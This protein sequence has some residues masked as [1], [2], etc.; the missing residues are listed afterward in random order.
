LKRQWPMPQ[1]KY[2]FFPAWILL[3][4]ILLSMIRWVQDQMYVFGFLC[5]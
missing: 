2:I 5:Q 3:C 4:S 1:Y